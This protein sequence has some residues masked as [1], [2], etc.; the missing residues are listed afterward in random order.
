MRPKHEESDYWVILIQTERFIQVVK[1]A[2]EK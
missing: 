1:K 2:K